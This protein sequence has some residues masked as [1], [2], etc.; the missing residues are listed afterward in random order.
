MPDDVSNPK[1]TLLLGYME[2]GSDN[3]HLNLG[4]LVSLPVFAFKN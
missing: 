3:E 1:G 2:A 4:E